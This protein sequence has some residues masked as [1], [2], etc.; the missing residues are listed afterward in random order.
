MTTE[1]TNPD[2]PAV[3][4][5]PSIDDISSSCL[6]R[7]SVTPSVSS[8][9]TRTAFLHESL[10]KVNFADHAR[11]VAKQIGKV[12]ND[13]MSAAEGML[14]AQALTLD[15]IF[16]DFARQAASRS[17]IPHLEAYMRMAMKAQA[18]CVATLRVIGE[19]KNPKQVSFVKQQNNAAGPQ[20]INNG[21]VTQGGHA[22]GNTEKAITTN[23]LLTDDTEARNGAT[24]DIGATGG[25]GRENQALETVGAVNGS[26]DA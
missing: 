18:Q 21:P 23:E 6:A 10:E 5:E 12:I 4:A 1:K 19:L 24:L 22:R 11:E 13:D 7:A 25:A 9:T 15:A 17:Q 3:R 16:N 14:M 2:S 26:E 20:Q 8:A